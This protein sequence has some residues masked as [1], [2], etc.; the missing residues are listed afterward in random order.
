VA[1]A[2]AGSKADRATALGIPII[3]EPTMLALLATPD[4]AMV[5]SSDR[6]ET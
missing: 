5:S 2:D 3:D 4:D 6:D 1:G